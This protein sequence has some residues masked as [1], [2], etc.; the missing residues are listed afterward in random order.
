MDASRVAIV[1][2]GARGLGLEITR[3]LA[4]RGFA[5]VLSYAM[6]QAAA[7]AAV[8]EVLAADGTALAVRA[9]VADELDVERLFT[10]TIEA[11]AEIDVVA[12][13]SSRLT[14]GHDETPGVS[15]A[16]QWTDMQGAFVVNQQASRHVRRGGTIVNLCGEPGGAPMWSTRAGSNG[17]IGVM[18]R[19]LARELHER[20]VTIN[21]VAYRPD[22]P[23]APAAVAAIV[24]LLVSRDARSL[25]GQTIQVDGG[26]G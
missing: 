13:A 24:G 23:S 20:D 17:A 12:H 9:D 10:E 21:A 25:T 2:G 11:F 7:E 5:V 18:T 8:E 4:G 14:L 19:A 16:Q 22:D 1:T 6:D 26:T 3:T 15:A